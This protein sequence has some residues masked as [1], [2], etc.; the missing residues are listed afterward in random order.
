MGKY[1]LPAEF[2][3][4]DRYYPTYGG[5]EDS[6]TFLGKMV[7]GL[8]AS[9]LP[10][11]PFSQ[12]DV[13][14][15]PW[16][17]VDGVKEFHLTLEYVRR[18][19]LPGKWMDLLGANGSCPGPYVEV[20]QGDTVRMVVHNHLSEPTSVHW[21]GAELPNNM[22]GVPGVTQDLI[23]P[24]EDFVYQ[25]RVHQAGTF[26]WHAHIPF[27]E[28][29]GT[30]GYFIIH[31]H[32]AW[33][34][35]VDRDFG[36]N[37]MN[38]SIAP[39]NTVATPFPMHPGIIGA[40]MWNWHIING[41]SAPYTT[42]LVCKLG[43]R[44][45]I[46]IFNFSINWPHAIHMHG[47]NFWITGHEGARQPVSAWQNR[48]TETIHIAQTS[49]LEFIATD[50][51]DWVMHCHMAMHMVNHP[52]PQYGPRIREGVSVAR[53]KAN[54]DDRPPVKFPHTDPGFLN[55]SFPRGRYSKDYTPEEV[56]KINSKREVR[57]MRHNWFTDIEGLFTVVR[58]L[59]EDLYE[60]VMNS[61]TPTR[62]RRD[63]PGSRPTPRTATGGTRKAAPAEARRG[64]V[65]EV[66]GGERRA[67][68]EGIGL[69]P[70]FGVFLG[71]DSRNEE[72][73]REA[74]RP[75]DQVARGRGAE[76][77]GSTEPTPGL[78]GSFSGGTSGRIQIFMA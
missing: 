7:P 45:R 31:P 53:Y 8:R 62:P 56:I 70:A 75:R 72:E 54:L 44:V 10:P 6:P 14:R 28:P 19:L 4:Y 71:M 76:D 59:P 48:N 29:L 67:P 24:G 65:P 9:G 25:F 1:D 46:R 55:P 2:K 38:F 41:R 40:N 35:P 74:P 57:G 20:T 39:N 68:E 30:V 73:L 78:I 51:G 37:F 12:P 13:P 63:L 5:P 22:D 16:K 11:V 34:P 77:Q 32:I 27:Q 50:P 33:D 61:E 66:D 49:D 64:S 18:E 17:M 21:H 47:T 36:L 60:Q 58:I 52:T 23:E 43:E 42:P 3:I 15:L 26:F 69:I